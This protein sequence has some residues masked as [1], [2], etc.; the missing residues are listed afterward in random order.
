MDST[1]NDLVDIDDARDLARDSFS[2][3]KTD[4]R[5]SKAACEPSIETGPICER[6]DSRKMVV[7][8]CA[9]TMDPVGRVVAHYAT[10]L[11]QAHSYVGNEFSRSI[12][13]EIAFDPDAWD[14]PLH[15][16]FHA[17]NIPTF[18][19]SV[20]HGT[21]TAGHAK[22][23]RALSSLR[24]QGVCIIGSGLL[25]HNLQEFRSRQI[26]SPTAAWVSDFSVWM[27]ERLDEH[28]TEALLDY[29]QQ[30]PFAVENHP[31]DEHLMPLFVA[32][33][34]AGENWQAERIHHSVEYGVF[35]MDFYAFS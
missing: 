22:L 24:E 7:P 13:S 4:S 17:A 23:G 26:D 31:S 14:A 19:V 6:E 28:A 34:A 30:A 32:M 18:Q 3:H 1:R 33:G 29:R 27:H 5:S 25:T 10:E 16:M 2:C 15:L 35:A 20:M 9:A 21:S 11:N 12:A 8:T